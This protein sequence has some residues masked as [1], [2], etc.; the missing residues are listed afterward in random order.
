MLIRLLREGMR[1]WVTLLAALGI[2]T[3]AFLSALH[4]PL[5]T[6]LV[7]VPVTAFLA[8]VLWHSEKRKRR[9]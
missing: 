3:I 8:R 2:G 6:A 9:R 1:D 7:A 4:Y 5:F